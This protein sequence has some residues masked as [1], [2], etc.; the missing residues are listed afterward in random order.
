MEA[1]FATGPTKA[2]GEDGFP[3]LFYQKCW[4]TIEDDVTTFCLQILNGGREV[5]SI[6]STNIV[7]IPKIPHPSNMSQFRPISLCNI[8]YKII[9][10]AIA[11]RLSEVIGK[12]IDETQ[13]AF[14]PGRLI[15]DNVLLAYEILHKLKQKRLGKKRYMAVKLDMSKGFDRVEWD[16]L[17]R[18]ML[19]I[20]FDQSWVNTI[21]HCVTSISYSVIINGHIREKFCPARGLRQGDPL[22]LFFSS[23]MEKGYLAC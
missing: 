12:C 2:P 13:S 8:L 5:S 16:F 22:S 18:I 7:L 23:Y 17:N 1:I 11:N 3:A 15:S 9:A 14:V 10:K 20:R 6:N 21:M 4:Q 19:Q